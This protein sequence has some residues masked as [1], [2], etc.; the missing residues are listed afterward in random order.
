MF[1]V[2]WESAQSAEAN[3]YALT[4]VKGHYLI[5]EGGGGDIVMAQKYFFQFNPAHGYFSP[6]VL[7]LTLFLPN[8]FCKDFHKLPMYCF[9]KGI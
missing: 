6:A 9:V 4:H 1:Y 2:W 5:T 3:T 8:H 7:W